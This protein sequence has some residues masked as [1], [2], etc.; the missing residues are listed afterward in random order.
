[1][2]RTFLITTPVAQAAAQVAPPPVRVDALFD[3]DELL[4]STKQAHRYT[5]WCVGNK[6]NSFIIG[7]IQSHLR[8][9]ER[10]EREVNRPV[11]YTADEDQRN[12]MAEQDAAIADMLA[13]NASMEANGFELA[14][15]SIEVAELLVNLRSIVVQKLRYIAATSPAVG[16]GK[17]TRD[18]EQTIAESLAYR[19][20]QQPAVNETLVMRL[21]LQTK[22]PL[23]ALRKADL[24]GQIAA[25]AALLVHAP[26]IQEIADELSWKKQIDA[27]SAESIFD[28]LPAATR[29]RL[30]LGVV[31]I[32][33][34]AMAAEVKAL[35]RFNR[36]DAMANYA[37]L[38]PVLAAYTEWFKRF[39]HDNLDELSAYE[40][41]GF[42]LPTLEQ[43]LA[44][45]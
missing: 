6:L 8:M 19:L 4:S 17:V 38:E 10:E 33:N 42:G 34:S 29:Y 28:M 18:P 27:A 30:I 23:A 45:A 22:F 36:V 15:P 20:S 1:M 35:V 3:F 26:R 12:R 14:M 43:T 24:D 5:W 32:L 11:N 21:H 25:R 44:Q 7:N 31:K 41:R 40:E 37:I 16:L 13:K 2:S 9:I 39:T